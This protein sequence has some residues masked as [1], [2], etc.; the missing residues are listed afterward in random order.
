M[1]TEQ[2]SGSV[3]DMKTPGCNQHP[4]CTS[5]FLWLM[6]IFTG[7]V[8][9]VLVTKN[10]DLINDDDDEKDEE[11]NEEDMEVEGEEGDQET[12][13]DEEEGISCLYD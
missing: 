12:G 8:L 4:R 1:W 5:N 13:E 10:D 11:E 3:S 2:Y 7:V 6:G 9:Q